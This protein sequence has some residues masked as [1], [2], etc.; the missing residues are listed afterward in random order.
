MSRERANGN[1]AHR[2]KLKAAPVARGKIVDLNVMMTVGR[3]QRKIRCDGVIVEV[4]PDHLMVKVFGG[5]AKPD[6]IVRV[7]RANDEWRLRFP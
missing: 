4:Y 7:D 6:P 5:V 3:T 1:G 2:P